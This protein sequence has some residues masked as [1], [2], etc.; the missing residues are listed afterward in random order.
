MKKTHRR[1]LRCD[2]LESRLLMAGNITS[3]LDGGVLTLTGDQLDNLSFVNGTGVPGQ[4]VVQPVATTIDGSTTPKTFNGVDSVVVNGNDG[5]DQFSFQNLA[6][7]DLTINLGNGND[8]MVTATQFGPN[9][10]GVTGALVVDAGTGNDVVQLFRTFGD[11]DMTVNA[12]D[13]N[14]FVQTYSNSADT[15]TVNLGQGFDTLNTAYLTA[16]GVWTVHGGTESDLFSVIT[17]SARDVAFF[18]GEDAAD[19]LAFNANEFRQNVEFD[20]G[21]GNDTM[22]LRN[23]IV[24]HNVFARLGDGLDSAEFQNNSIDELHLDAGRDRDVVTVNAN[25]VDLAILL[26]GSGD[27][28]LTVT[29]NLVRDYALLDG[30]SGN[31]R[32]TRS[33]NLFRHVDIVNFQT[34]V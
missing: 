4:V 1:K 33:G 3:S 7:T 14:D 12:G 17:S 19:T 9:S 22:F 10:V 25:A 18:F 34:I 5:N 15:V 8:F 23:S 2:S 27:D 26:M 24:L 20:A 6:V 30:G 32:L 21:A 28:D 29:N 13:G 16:F 11:Y 31:N